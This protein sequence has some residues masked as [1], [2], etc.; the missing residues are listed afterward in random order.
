MSVE[1]CPPP[2]DIDDDRPS[3]SP[4]VCLIVMREMLIAKDLALMIGDARPDLQVLL[5]ITQDAAL[6]QLTADV[7][8]VLAMVD[9][10]PQEFSASELAARVAASKAL[11]IHL[12]YDLPLEGKDS[13]IRAL[14]YPFGLDDVHDILAALP[15]KKPPAYVQGADA[16][17]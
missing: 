16:G 11:L 5:A 3:H 14:P 15:M 7:P 6:Q 9:M 12:G 8:V 10:H 17:W 2:A 1:R 4:P 13:N